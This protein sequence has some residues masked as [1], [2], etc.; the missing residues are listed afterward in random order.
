MP[1]GGRKTNRA[2]LK[3]SGEHS[4][5]T[6]DSTGPDP[7]A[8][9]QLSTT[10][11]TS[12]PASSPKIATRPKDSS[13]KPGVVQDKVAGNQRDTNTTASAEFRPDRLPASIPAKIAIGSI[14]SSHKHDRVAEKLREQ[15][16]AASAESRPDGI[17]DAIPAKVAVGQKKTSNDRDRVHDNVAENQCEQN[18][19]TSAETRPDGI[20]AAI[21]ATVAIG[22]KDSS[23]KRDRVQDKV[24]KNPR[25]RSITTS[26][27]S[28]PDP[29]VVPLPNNGT[30][31]P[32]SSVISNVRSGLCYSNGYEIAVGDL[33]VRRRDPQTMANGANK[34]DRVS[35]SH[36]M[37]TLANQ[38]TVASMI[39]STDH[40]R[41][42]K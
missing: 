33:V 9:N 42:S 14:D 16:T 30:P 24:A 34:Q 7:R 37:E 22:P 27:E 5:K 40:I 29:N 3:T 19:A 11:T 32:K 31:D 6:A 20:A 39:Y 8:A 17:P 28:K 15:D 25:E 12:L 13:Y 38:L 35:N 26:A 10:S 41:Y 1:K 36:Y 18:I 2:L 21:S 23:K 4:L